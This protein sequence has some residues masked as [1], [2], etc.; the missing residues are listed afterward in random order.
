MS[1]PGDVGGEVSGEEA[2]WRQLV[3]H[4]DVTAGQD[5]DNPPWP[6]RESLS[7]PGQRPGRRPTEPDDAGQR[8]SQNSLGLDGLGLNGLGLNGTGQDR[9]GQDRTGQDG[10]GLDGSGQDDS[11]Q[12]DT[13]QNGSRDGL[14]PDGAARGRTAPTPAGGY[15]A[16]RARIVRPA[17]DP[18]SYSPPD[19]PDDERYVPAPLPPVKLDPVAKGAWVGLI[20][21]PAYLLVGVLLGWTISG[22]AAFAA[23]AAFVIGFVILVLRLGDGSK[24]DDDDDGAV[25]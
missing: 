16:D 14:K 8:G 9:T 12:D 25:V 2:A 10:R 21:G 19:E 18:R 3:A 4:Y 20:G 1:G 5:L 22:I 13:A 6:E 17:G 15:F 23:I 11:E 7:E 24:R